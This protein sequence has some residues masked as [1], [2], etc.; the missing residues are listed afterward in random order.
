MLS[1]QAYLRSNSRSKRHLDI[2]Q[3][4]SD[5]SESLL[6]EWQRNM[7]ELK[8]S[9]RAELEAAKAELAALRLELDEEDSSASQNNI[10][11]PE[12]SSPRSEAGADDDEEPLPEGW[13][14]MFDKNNNRF[15]YVNR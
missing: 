2:P 4:N 9:L 3:N 11:N 7:E 13:K 12:P 10:T 5:L 14:K 8:A 15:Y 6:Y 1:S